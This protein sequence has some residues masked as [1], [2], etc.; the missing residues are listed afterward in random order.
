MPILFK[1][2]FYAAQN[3]KEKTS[4]NEYALLGNYPNPFNPSTTISYSLP[5]E[6]EVSI[7]IYDL[8]GSIIKSFVPSNQSAGYKNLLWDGR[9]NYGQLVT[10]G[11]YIYTIKAVSL[12]G[13]GKSF[14]KSS[15]VML[16]K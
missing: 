14:A 1:S 7:T 13:N 16:L 9:N 15:K 10:S 8:T 12:E 5:F 6:S 11:V 2:S 4:P 3:R